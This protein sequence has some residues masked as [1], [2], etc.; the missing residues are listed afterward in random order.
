MAIYRLIKTAVP[1]SAWLFGFLVAYVLAGCAAVTQNDTR[2]LLNSERIAAKFGSYGIEILEAAETLRVSNLFS[3][4]G[5][6]RTCRTFAIVMYPAAI[7]SAVA[8]EHATVLG[9]GSIGAVFAAGGWQV[10]KTHL[11]YGEREATAA[12]A[13]HMGVPKG[14]ALAEHA[15]VLEV[16]KGGLVIEYASLL[17]IHHPAYLSVTELPAIY[18]EIESGARADRVPELLATAAAWRER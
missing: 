7:D 10:R 17:E 4:E 3:I 2:E 5:G 9:G 8:A 15:Y 18:G 13:Q 16:Q 11:H 1:G 6:Q 14:T 12:I